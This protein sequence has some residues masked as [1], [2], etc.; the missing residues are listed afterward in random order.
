PGNT[1][2]DGMVVWT[3][4]DVGSCESF[5]DLAFRYSDPAKSAQNIGAVEFVRLLRSIRLW[6][7]LGW[8]IE[9]TDAAICALYRADLPP[10]GT[11]GVDGGAELDA[12]FPTLLP[13]LGIVSRVMKALNLTVKRDLLALLACFAPIGVYDGA[14][15]APDDEGGLQ[16]Q[17]VPSF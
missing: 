5:D 16:Q 8:T 10:I 7:K 14:E 2:N 13:R 6:K 9:Q 3:C 4:R 12:G 11:G 15:W 1:C 17:T